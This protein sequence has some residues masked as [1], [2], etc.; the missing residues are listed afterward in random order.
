MDKKGYKRSID[1]RFSETDLMGVVHHKNYF[2]WFDIARLSFM[3]EIIQIS[4]K[5]LL[6]LEFQMPVVKATCSYRNPLTLGDRVDIYT[7][8]SLTSTTLFT[9]HFDLYLDQKKVA[10]GKT[11]HVLIDEKKNLMYDLPEWFEKKVTMATRQYANF[12]TYY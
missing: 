8:L 11:D 12:I 9:F 1:I 4:L 10:Y 5:E 3:E 7:K 6:T 2:D